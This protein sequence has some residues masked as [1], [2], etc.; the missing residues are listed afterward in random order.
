MYLC[1]LDA[2]RGYELAQALKRRSDEWM[3]RMS[4]ASRRLLGM[5][6]IFGQPIMICERQSIVLADNL[7]FAAAVSAKIARVFPPKWGQT[8]WPIMIW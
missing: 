6:V 8:A 2:W 7:F 5:I 1:A 3:K 4:N